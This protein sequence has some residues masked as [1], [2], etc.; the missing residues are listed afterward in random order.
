MKSSNDPRMKRTKAV[1]TFGTA[2]G[3]HVAVVNGVLEVPFCPDTGS[4]SN[5]VSSRIVE[6][7]LDLDTTVVPILLEQP[8]TVQVAGGGRMECHESVTVDLCIQTAAGSLQLRNV[9]CL[10]L[11]GQEGELLLGRR[12]MQ[13]IGID[14]DGILEELAGSG[15]LDQADLD[16]LDDLGDDDVLVQPDVEIDDALKHLIEEAM[17]EGFDPELRDG[18]ERLIYEY[19]DVWRLKIGRDVAAKVESMQ[20]LLCPN[21]EPHRCGMRK[22]PDS[23][24]AFL[25]DYVPEENGL[26]VRN[27]QSRWASAAHPALQWT[28]V[29]STSV[30]CPSRV[31]P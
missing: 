26:V 19:A 23:Q 25:R 10:V 9:R 28:T 11:E 31:P 16:D 14:I 6:E 5:I 7:L 1:K 21:V 30:R 15:L 29:N 3:D 20:V 24:R 22:Y 18:F 2:A 17:A 13:E 27:N 8:V 12:T 4:D